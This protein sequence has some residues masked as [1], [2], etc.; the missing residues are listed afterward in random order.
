[1]KLW[2]KPG[3]MLLRL[4]VIGVI[5]F[6]VMSPL[7]RNVVTATVLPKSGFIAST[8]PRVLAQSG[9]QPLAQHISAQLEASLKQLQAMQGASLDKPFKVYVFQSEDD[10][11]R[12]GAC[13][14]GAR[15]CAFRGNVSLSPKL[16]AELATAP[17]I[18]THELS[19]VLMQQRMG[20]WGASQVPPWFSEGLAVV[21]ADGGGAEGVGREEALA[22]IAAGQRFTPHLEGSLL[23]P[24]AGDYFHMPHRLFYRQ[25]ALFVAHLRQQHP[26]EF[27]DLLL[28]LHAGMQ[29]E[30]AFT[31]A[32]N[33]SV[34]TLWA[35]FLQNAS[36]PSNTPS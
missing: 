33:Q 17:A 24:R 5:A 27:S 8:D 4:G 2:D 31:K 1:M 10:F 35:Q 7:H 3:K 20:Q 6:F 30:A 32:F 25:S 28:R 12:L 36:A 15:A 9:A 22:A 13:P 14:A 21:V 11:S 34:D 26:A 23:R 29:F 16:A 19:H 18:L